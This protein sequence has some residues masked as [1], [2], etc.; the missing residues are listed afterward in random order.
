MKR[1]PG[2]QTRTAL[3]ATIALGSAL[4]ALPAMAQSSQNTQ[5]LRGQIT[6]VSD[7]GFTMTT[8]NDGKRQVEL[9]SQTKISAVTPG[10]LSNIQKG[11]FIG[12]ANVQQNGQN[13]ALEMVI[14]PPSMK[15][16]GL[17]DYGWDL[18]PA[19]ANQ[20]AT[21]STNAQSGPSKT[22]GGSSMT[23]GT[24][25]SESNASNSNGSMTSGSSMTNGTVSSKS[26]GS[27]SMTS[28]SSMT[29]GT[30]SS[31]S[32]GSNSMSSGSS[33][34]N[35]TVSSENN[36]SNSMSSGSSMTNGTVAGQSGG[37]QSTTL[38]VD[39]GKGSKKIVVPNDVP[40]VK[41]HPGNQSDLKK[42]AHVFVVGPKTSGTF[43][44]KMVI[45]GKNGTIPPM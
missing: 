38:T 35:G 25:T 44:A 2:Q 20:S 26:S 28:G 36:G 34:T 43:N 7:N 1:Y 31:K 11:T 6:S 16:T 41:V 39:Y 33:M 42:G 37:N 22:A 19:M 8:H 40:T 45:V 5:H 4:V 9:S 15:G 24:V 30:V 23:N 3:V 32:N 17:G 14:F 21:V 12:T 10:D 27:G 29:N 18:T 13:R